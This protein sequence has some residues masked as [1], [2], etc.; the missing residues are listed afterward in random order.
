MFL[1]AAPSDFADLTR[2]APRSNFLC[3]EDIL[4]CTFKHRLHNHAE[5]RL[6]TKCNI[7]KRENNEKSACVKTG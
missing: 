4:L 7:P 3:L 5:K 1:S 6:Q 2:F